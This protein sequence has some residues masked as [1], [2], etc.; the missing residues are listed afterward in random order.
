[1]SKTKK[2]TRLRRS[3]SYIVCAYC[4]HK[5]PTKTIGVPDREAIFAHVVACGARPESRMVKLIMLQ[6]R[7]IKYLRSAVEHAL[8]EIGTAGDLGVEI[9]ECLIDTESIAADLGE[10]S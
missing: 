5:T 1:M 3:A 2:L 6:Q 7:A 10:G 4:G 9:A 8:A